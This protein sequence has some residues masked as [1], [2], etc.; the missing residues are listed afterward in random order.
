MLS[1]VNQSHR[2]TYRAIYWTGWLVLVLCAAAAVWSAARL[3]WTLL[4]ADPDTS[5]LSTPNHPG[6]DV[7]SRGTGVDVA[8]LHLFGQ[9]GAMLQTASIEAPETQLSLKLL[10]TFAADQPVD[11]LAIIADESGQQGYYGTGDELPGG[12]TLEEVHLGRVVL[13]YQG[14]LESLPL[15]RSETGDQRSSRGQ[16]I[17]ENRSPGARTPR[18]LNGS[19]WQAARQ[20]SRLDTA[21]LAELGRQIRALPHIEN[22]ET[23]G[24]RLMAAQDASVLQKLGLRSSDIILSVNGIPLSDASRQFEL[25]NQLNDQNQFQVRLRRQGREMTLNIDASQLNKP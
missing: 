3:L 8:E 25:M 13:R 6:G 15:V 11:G 17:A 21:K 22:G 2:A 10:G 1:A 24:V 19:D 7:D 18:S 9:V 20:Q 12:A 14:R 4:P 16:A 23:V 5:T